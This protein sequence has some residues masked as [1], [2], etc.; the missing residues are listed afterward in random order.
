MASQLSHEYLNNL[1]G[2][3]WRHPWRGFYD[4]LIRELGHKPETWDGTPLVLLFFDPP[5]KWRVEEIPD[6]MKPKPDGGGA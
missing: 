5:N 6:W 2:A 4:F 1:G 3:W